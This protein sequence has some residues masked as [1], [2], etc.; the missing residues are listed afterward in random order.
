MRA[1]LVLLALALC[2]SSALANLGPNAECKNNR[3][4]GVTGTCRAGLVCREIALSGKFTCHP[5]KGEPFD[6]TSNNSPDTEAAWEDAKKEYCC[7]THLT[8]CPNDE[9]SEY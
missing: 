5:E 3:N 9:T 4:P 1:L 7:L 8:G 2:V 6:C